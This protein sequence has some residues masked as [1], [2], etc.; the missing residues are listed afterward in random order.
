MSLM[1]IRG[2]SVVRAPCAVFVLAAAIALLAGCPEA[3]KPEVV[4]SAK[5]DGESIVF[6]KDSPQLTSLVMDTA[7]EQPA[8]AIR[9]NGRLAWNEDHTVR[10]FTPFAGRV[11]SIHAQP[12]DNVKQGQMLAVIASPDFGQAQAETRRAQ[13]DFALARQNLARAKDLHEHGVV[14]AKDLNAAEAEFARTESEI[15]RT[16]AR[17]KFYGGGSEIDQTYGL[18]SPLTG[19]VVE[20]NINPGQE[21]RPDQMVANAPAL[22]VITNPS[23]LWVLLDAVEK[24]LPNLK[25]GSNL[26]IKVPT[27]PNDEFQAK[28]AAISDF[29]DPVTRTIKVRA[30]IDNTA[31]KLKGEM[32]INAEAKSSQASVIKVPARAVMFQGG[33]YYLFVEDGVGRFVRREVVTAETDDGYVSIASGVAAGQRVVAEGALLLQQI[34]Q[35]RRIVK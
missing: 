10:V 3:P 16:E 9:L 15:K 35:P 14:A 20:K 6:L 25:V 2:Y 5:I 17:L 34:L 24:D 27:Y 12:G 7:V 22:F 4:P 13:G 29:L 23:S 21:L 33:R 26:K 30:V 19:V 18:K 31:R 11:A 32:F 8:G 28:I 1:E